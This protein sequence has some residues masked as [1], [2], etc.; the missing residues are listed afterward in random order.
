MHRLAHARTLPLAG[1]LVM[2]IFVTPPLR[3]FERQFHL[4]GGLG[5]AK[6]S[7]GYA[8]GPALGI[9]SAYG[10]TD[11]YDLR[12]ELQ[13][14]RSNLG[15]LPVSFYGARLGLAY[16]IDVMRLIPY[17]GV[18]AGGF[19]VAW[20]GGSLVR[21]SGGA[22]FGLDYGMS[23]HVGLGVLV[24]GDFIVTNPAVIVTSVLLRAE[25]RADF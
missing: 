1:A 22:Y 2:L 6:P 16:K 4:G 12:L 17:A 5:A 19:A 10:L 15:A 7:G 24:N 14:S 9:H 21:P 18:S 13:G 3:A 20:E 8:L 11:A 25:Y 23:P